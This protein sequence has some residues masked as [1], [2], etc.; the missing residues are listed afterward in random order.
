MTRTIG[1]IPSVPLSRFFS[2][3]FSAKSVESARFHESLFNAL[4]ETPFAEWFIWQ[5]RSSENS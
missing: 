3:G 4:N 1:L 2:L 5:L